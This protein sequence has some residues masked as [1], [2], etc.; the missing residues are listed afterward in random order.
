MSVT[1]SLLFFCFYFIKYILLRK[2]VA[3]GLITCLLF[4]CLVRGGSASL[5]PP[6]KEVKTGKKSKE[7]KHKKKK[8]YKH[9]KEKKVE[10]EE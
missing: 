1:L 10:N 7:K 3:G 8:H 4:L 6:I 9:K 5:R 2:S